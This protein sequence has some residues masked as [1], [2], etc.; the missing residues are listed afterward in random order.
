MIDTVSFSVEF[1]YGTNDLFPDNGLIT[2]DYDKRVSANDML[3]IG[4][5]LMHQA[6]AYVREENLLGVGVYT[7][8]P[9]FILMIDESFKNG[10]KS[11]FSKDQG[12]LFA[13]YIK[14]IQNGSTPTTSEAAIAL[15]TYLGSR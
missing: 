9:D 15:N 6:P 5:K 4:A 13:D 8:N 3:S 7:W 14:Y 1:P 11:N 2:F 10:I 12:K